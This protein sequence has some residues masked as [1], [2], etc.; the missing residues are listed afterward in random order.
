[1]TVS[2]KPSKRR[3]KG[4]FTLA[5]AASALLAL[6]GCSKSGEAKFTAGTYTG[7]AQG[8]GGEVNVTI[9]TDASSIL[10]VTATG[11]DETP[12]IGG[13][14][15]DALAAQ[16]LEAQSSEIDGVSGATITSR[17]V[18]L[19][20]AAA[21]DA[22]SGNVAGGERQAVRDGTY[23]GSAPSYG[24]INEMQ[25]SVTFKDNRI[26]DITTIKA[27][28]AVQST[29]DDY[30]PIY[31]T[32]EEKFYPRIIE[33]QSLAVDSISGATTS[34]NAARTIIANIIDNNGGDS[35][36]WY[37]PIEKSTETVTL[38]G[39]DVIV[40]GLGAAGLTSYLSAAENGAT[41]FGFDAAGKIGGNGSTTS[42]PLGVNPERQVALNGGRNFVDP[43]ELF[44]AWMEYTED[45]AKPEL[46]R[47]FI[48]ESGNTFG[49][50]ENNWDFRFMDTMLSFFDPHEWQLWTIYLDST[51]TS[52][53]IAY[54]NSIEKAKAMNPKNDYMTELR[55]KSLLVDES[56]KAIGVEA[57]YY[58][59]TTYLIY[60]DAIILATG[61]FVGNAKMSMAYTGNVWHTNGMDQCDGFSIAESVRLGGALYNEDAGVVNHIAQVDPIIRSDKYSNDDKSILTSLV[62]D[63][64]YQMI[65]S[66]GENFD[67]GETAIDVSFN[68]WLAGSNYYVLI[69]EAE[70]NAI[71]TQGLSSFN[72][73]ISFEQGGSY[74]PGTPVSN[75]DS[76]MAMGQ[77]FG[78]VFIADS[79]D[80]LSRQIGVDIKIGNVHGQT[81]GKIYC[82]KG[83]AYIYS[84]GGGVDIDTNMNLLKEDGAPVENIYV[85]GTDSLGV[86]SVSNKSYVTYGGCA[87]GWALTSGRL[88]GA[89]AAAKYA[90]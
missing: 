30:S 20:A 72:T 62:L 22:A 67:C 50:L 7:V 46:V 41:V 86:L 21:I 32:V 28:S 88:A 61:G 3:T 66:R 36:Q 49:W 55:A 51:M 81:E 24:V 35:S 74:E 4:L 57:E 18:M 19:A 80:D 70:Y 54:V 83:A 16:V 87:Q 84:T 6:A 34:S 1:M 53:E 42:G 15:L 12:A 58:D 76:I 29:Q 79:L 48:E 2:Q 26:T 9:T 25:L 52:K 63:P 13:A 27:G 82:I 65:D 64:S 33:S 11:D 17:A 39:Y 56:G 77:E 59:G 69:N 75:I 45:D 85:V 43:D 8:Y 23:T 40:V 47:L 38:E 89:N 37:T 31:A 78:N 71:K 90:N 73:P 68:S 10:S 44:D 60:G 5:A 14:A